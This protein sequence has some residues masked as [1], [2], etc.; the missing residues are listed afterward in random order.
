MKIAAPLLAALLLATPAAHAQRQPTVAMVTDLA[1]EVRIEGAR[2][3]VPAGIATELPAQ[4]RIDAAAGARVVVL[5]LATGDEYTLSGPASARVGADGLTGA[6]PAQLAR[7]ASAVGKV[8]LK[9]DGLAQA[10][11]TLRAARP[12]ETLPLLGLAG[13]VTLD[14]RPVFRWSPVVGVGPYRFELQDA[15]GAVLHE[16]RTEVTEIRLPEGMALVEGRSYTW[17]VSARRANGMR[18]STF[19]DFTV[20]P[21]SLRA[22]AAR[23]RP[24]ADAPRAGRASSRSC[25]GRQGRGVTCRT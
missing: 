8:R 3:A 10:A 23:L 20:A 17:E 16:T 7:R 9:G 18:F 19:G 1:G 14:T 22:E 6:P 2:G 24:R 25:T 12:Q 4:A 13:T 15:N 11:V 21:A 5:V